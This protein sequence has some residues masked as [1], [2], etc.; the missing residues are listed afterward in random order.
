MKIIYTDRAKQELARA[1]EWYESHQNS[2]G[3][4]FLNAVET[5]I[6]SFSSFPE[7]YAV[8]YAQFRRCVIKRFPYS[9]FYTLEGQDVVIHAVFN[10]KQDPQGLP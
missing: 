10:N 4:E 9:L 3:F 7:L 5:S 6:S 8:C 2:L 1:F